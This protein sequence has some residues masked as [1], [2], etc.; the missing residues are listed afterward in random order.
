MYSCRQLAHIR[1]FL[2]LLEMQLLFKWRPE[3]C[4]PTCR[5][6]DQQQPVELRTFSFQPYFQMSL[7]PLQINFS[8]FFFVPHHVR[9]SVN[10]SFNPSP[11]SVD[12]QHNL[13]IVLQNISPIIN[14]SNC[15]LFTPFLFFLLCAIELKLLRDFPYF[16]MNNFA[17]LDL[18]SHQLLF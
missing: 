9:R 8:S 3:E 11:W 10:P 6:Y 5:N 12:H 16:C 17:K 2:D 13:F 15:R 18:T 4:L 14:D 1:L 7:F